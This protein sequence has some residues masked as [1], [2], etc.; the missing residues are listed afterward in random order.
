MGARAYICSIS[1]SSW[2]LSQTALALLPTK[3]P[4]TKMSTSATNPSTSSAVPLPRR[5]QELAAAVRV[6]PVWAVT[7]AADEK[8]LKILEGCAKSVG[9]MS[10]CCNTAVSWDTFMLRV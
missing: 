2:A 5:P 3:P 8:D 4:P 10:T 6:Q 1:L 9:S 7:P